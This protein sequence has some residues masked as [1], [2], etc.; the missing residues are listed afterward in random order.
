MLLIG[1][2]FSTPASDVRADYVML[3]RH[4]EHRFAGRYK[5]WDK[6]V[7]ALKRF[8]WSDIAFPDYVRPFWE[9]VHGIPV[10]EREVSIGPS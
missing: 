4:N 7:A 6:T 8:I 10:P 9:E 5:T 2:G 3:F 1:G